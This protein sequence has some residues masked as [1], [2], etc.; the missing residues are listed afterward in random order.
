MHLL[1]VFLVPSLPLISAT[2]DQ[3]D[4]F[5]C[6][7]GKVPSIS[8]FPDNEDAKNH[9]SM[10]PSTSISNDAQICFHKAVY[11]VYVDPNATYIFG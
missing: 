4:D 9:L 1:C 5:C 2:I 7:T 3:D 11:A 6:A 8:C 10:Y